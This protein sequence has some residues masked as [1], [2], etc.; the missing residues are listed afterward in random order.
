MLT[1]EESLPSQVGPAGV[2]RFFSTKAWYADFLLS[3]YLS[4]DPIIFQTAPSAFQQ[5]SGTQLFF[6]RMTS[7]L[8]RSSPGPRTH[9]L[10]VNKC[11]VCRFSSFERPQHRLGWAALL[12]DYL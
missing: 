6:I 3:K 4:I 5:K 11:L 9:G 12:C 8:G 1:L 10:F 7:A 2:C